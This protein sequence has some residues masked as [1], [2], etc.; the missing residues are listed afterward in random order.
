MDCRNCGAPMELFA[1]RRYFFCRY[2]GTFEF[3]DSPAE[4][5]VQVLERPTS[6]PLCPVC[7]GPLAI[8]LLDN[9]FRVQHC[10]ACRGLLIACTDFADAVA[11]RRSRESGPPSV[12]IPLDRRDLTR[13]LACPSCH[14]TMDVHP[15]YGPGNVVIDTCDRCNVVWL[16][17]GELKQIAD[18][19]GRDRQQSWIDP[20]R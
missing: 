14:E 8:A 10:A 17:F 13:H 2:C 5:G 19:P 6:A 1:E 11:A 12:P 18:A 9:T 3:I 20:A 15:Y 16:D 7:A 4:D